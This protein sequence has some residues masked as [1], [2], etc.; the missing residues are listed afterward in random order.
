MHSQQEGSPPAKPLTR[1]CP[2]GTLFGCPTGLQNCEKCLLFEA[3]P[4]RD[5]SPTWP[6]PCLSPHTDTSLQKSCFRTAVSLSAPILYLGDSSHNLPAS[7]SPAKHSHQPLQAGP[8]SSQTSPPLA[9]LSHLLPGG[10]SQGCFSLSCP[11]PRPMP[12][13]I[14]V[15]LCGHCPFD[16]FLLNPAFFK[17]IR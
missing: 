13:L 15:L 9:K 6:R 8:P 12:P 4:F 3:H 14:H 7:S 1:T 17:A 2:A 10:C 11:C 5:G 16:A